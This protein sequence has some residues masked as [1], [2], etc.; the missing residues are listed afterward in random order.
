MNRKETS[1]AGRAG[2]I[3]PRVVFE[4][5]PDFVL[6]ARLS[7]T[8]PAGVRRV[9]VESLSSGVL[10]PSPIQPNITKPDLLARA[11]QAVT[12]T[13]RNGGGRLGLLLPD[14]VARVSVVSFGTLPAKSAELK[15]LLN[16]RIKETLGFAPEDAQISW[17]TS[18]TEAG[19]VEFLLVAIKR[20]VL[21]QYEASLKALHAAPVLILPVTLALLALLPG[22][23]PGVQLLTH[24]YSGWVTHVVV[25]GNR[26]RLWRNRPLS[27]P[28]GGAGTSEIISEAAR[29]VNSTR[30]RLGLEI[31]RG[32]CCVRPNID[33]EL[34]QELA[35]TLGLPV[36][37]LSLRPDF[38]AAL[39]SEE[40]ILFAPFGAPLAGL[41]VNS[42]KAS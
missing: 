32:W 35:R 36:E 9:A 14:A 23:E 39:G 12:Q 31:T 20:N 1:A 38:G 22:D 2:F 5:E 25:E 27:G 37:N 29:A 19:M 18:H 42:G 15:A 33:D 26:L 21:R 8:S 34:V 17:Q 40:K 41:I 16:W 6:A 28:V 30:D 3:L 11:L 4:I 7:H 13:V 10:D 24:A